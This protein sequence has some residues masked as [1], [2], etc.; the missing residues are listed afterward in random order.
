ME[1]RTMFR[2]ESKKDR[3]IR[4]LRKLTDSLEKDYMEQLDKTAELSRKLKAVTNELEKEKSKDRRSAFAEEVGLLPCESPACA[5]CKRAVW[6]SGA[7][8]RHIAGCSKGI[9]CADFEQ[10]QK[11]ADTL[12]PVTPPVVAVLPPPN[13]GNYW[14]PPF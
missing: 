8:G 2:F 10:T 9:K 13:Y 14:L 7:D 1:R 11:D 6:T 3:Q 4:E 12:A 5:Q